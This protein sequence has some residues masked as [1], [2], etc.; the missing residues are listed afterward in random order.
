M[1]INWIKGF[2]VQVVL[3]DAQVMQN[4]VAQVLFPLEL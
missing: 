1:R 4:S 3:C 2:V